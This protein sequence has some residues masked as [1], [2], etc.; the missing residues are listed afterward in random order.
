[1][2]SLPRLLDGSLNEQERLQPISLSLEQNM[3]PLSTAT[4]MLPAQQYAVAAGQYIE[5][6]TRQGSA[7]I[8]RAQ[9]V[10]Q[11]TGG[12]L[13]V[14]LEH[15][16]VSMADDIIPQKTEETQSP[17]LDVL[18]LIMQHQSMWQLGRVEIPETEMVTWSCDYSNVLE[19]LLS[20]LEQYPDHMLT[21]DQTTRPWTLNIIAVSDDNPSECRLSR[22]LTSLTVETDRSEMCTRLYIPMAGGDPIVLDADT[23]DAWGV[24]SRSMTGDDGLTEDELRAEGQ[25]YLDEHK[26]PRTT[27]TIDAIDL[28][29][30]TG[31]SLDRFH[32]GRMCRV[33][34]PDSAQVINHRVTKITHPDVYG[35]P[36]HVQLTL[37]DKAEST[38]DVLA[39]LVVQTTVL[40]KTVMSGPQGQWMTGYFLQSQPILSVTKNAND[41]V[42]DVSI[43]IIGNFVDY[44]GREYKEAQ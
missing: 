26:H 7:G 40:R 34:L 22:N 27:V 32:L 16:I 43:S 44:V 11:E 10:E 39:G 41:L 19:S 42:T 15:G 28:S 24:I 1:M 3:H 12:V 29:A 4:L 25:R 31:E 5:L 37:A 38:A 13:R 30:A 9:Q 33:C 23:Q 6:Y 35:D 8:F 14:A 20:V 2:I 17:V 18:A 36:D 21:Y